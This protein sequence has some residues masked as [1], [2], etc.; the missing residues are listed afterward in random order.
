VEWV[1]LV[2][3]VS[4]ALVGAL[5]A[6]AG[7]LPGRDLAR[8]VV[9]RTLCAIRLTGS[10]TAV[11]ELATEY[12]AEL[13]SL[14]REQAPT[15][16]YEDGMR[17]LPVDWRRCRDD[18]CS[19]GRESGVVLESDAGEPVTA[20]VHVVDCRPGSAAGP[21][22][23]YD[24]SGGRDGRVYLQYWLYYPGSQSLDALPGDIGHHDDDWE[25]VQVRIEPD[26]SALA[27]ASSHH[28]YN[29]RGGM[30]NWLSDAGLDSRPGWGPA[31]GAYHVS[32]GSHAGHVEGDDDEPRWTPA[33]DI[34]LVPIEPVARRVRGARRAFAVTPPWDKEV[35]LDPES[36]STG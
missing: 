10:C 15:I 8:T 35:Y 9:Q 1:A 23:G 36:E 33:A 34:R 20:F 28:G 18:G 19:L 7:E 30:R 26:G 21:A 5:M 11:D 27:R 14:V 16:R 32:G 24:C 25:S 17:A 3:V 22:A 29:H 12:G 13:A 31:S 2:L 6:I 4:L